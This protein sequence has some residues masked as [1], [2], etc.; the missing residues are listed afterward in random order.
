ML[1]F[2]RS[3]EKQW[4]AVVFC[5]FHKLLLP[6]AGE[7]SLGQLVLEILGFFR[8]SEQKRSP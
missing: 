6:F 4:D 1:H 2:S 3:W 7:H 5:S 8:I